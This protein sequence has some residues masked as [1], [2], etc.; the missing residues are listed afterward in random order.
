MSKASK[1]GAGKANKKSIKMVIIAIVSVLA[2]AA[3]IGFAIFC[4]NE[5][6]KGEDGN[7]IPGSSQVGGGNGGVDTPPIP[8]DPDLFE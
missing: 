7:N 3:V 6:K 5:N 8:L 2:I 4:A 1:K